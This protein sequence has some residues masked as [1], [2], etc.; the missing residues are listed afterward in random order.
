M[1]SIIASKALRR[2]PDFFFLSCPS[3]T[4][5]DFNHL[6]SNVPR[7]LD[8]LWQWKYLQEIPGL[9]ESEAEADVSGPSTVV[10]GVVSCCGPGACY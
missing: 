9:E 5:K 2:G 6:G 1:A 4:S 8:G 7:V 3:L 10:W